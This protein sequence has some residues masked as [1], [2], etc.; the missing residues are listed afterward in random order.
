MTIADTGHSVA[1]SEIFPT[2]SCFYQVLPTIKWSSLG[3]MNRKRNI[4]ATESSHSQQH[5]PFGFTCTHKS[6]VLH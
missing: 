1:E 4:N 5:V 6:D 2:T 3:S